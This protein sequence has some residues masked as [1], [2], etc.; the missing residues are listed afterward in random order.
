MNFF[1]AFYSDGRMFSAYSVADI[2]KVIPHPD[3]TGRSVIYL[4][5]AG[6]DPEDWRKVEVF[7]PLAE[8]LADLN[9]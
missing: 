8:V 6:Q 2:R 9:P 5:S 4:G 3:D 7:K 1:P